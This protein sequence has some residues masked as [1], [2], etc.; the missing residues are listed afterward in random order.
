MGFKNCWDDL[1]DEKIFPEFYHYRGRNNRDT[2]FLA[3]QL[4]RLNR[5]N[6]ITACIE[7]SERYKR[8]N[9][10]FANLWLL[11]F[12]NKYGISRKD[13]EAAQAA[14]AET[15]GSVWEALERVKAAQPL[16]RS[17]FGERFK[18]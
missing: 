11:D 6:R 14:I 18:E 2:K 17:K 16:A 10:D 8:L 5:E 1:P 7:Y 4:N 13:Y 9:R 15:N 3:A 12:V